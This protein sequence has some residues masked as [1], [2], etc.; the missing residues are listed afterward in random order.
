MTWMSNGRERKLEARL[1][2]V[3]LMGLENIKENGGN[4]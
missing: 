2:K 4:L 3:E 1:V